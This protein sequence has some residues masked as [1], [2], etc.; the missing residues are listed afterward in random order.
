MSADSLIKAQKEHMKTVQR[1]NVSSDFL[2]ELFGIQN[3]RLIS[4]DKQIRRELD[5]GV[6]YEDIVKNIID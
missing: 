6:E 1:K 3:I 2:V 5:K 4:D